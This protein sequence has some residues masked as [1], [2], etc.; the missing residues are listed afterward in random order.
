MHIKI[1]IYIFFYYYYWVDSFAGGLLVSERIIRPV[2]NALHNVLYATFSRK[3][4]KK[5]RD[6]I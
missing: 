4:N 6:Q 3:K 2:L 1:D 5:D